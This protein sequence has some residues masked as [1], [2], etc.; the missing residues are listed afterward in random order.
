MFIVIFIIILAILIAS[1]EFGHFIVAKLSGIRVDEFG[2]GFPP[3]IVGKRWGETVYTLNWIPF[4]GFVR[5]FGEEGNEGPDSFAGKH[6]LIQAGV[7]VAG[8]VFNVLLAF[9]LLWVGL[10]VGLEAST[11]AFPG[12]HYEDIHVVVTEVVPDSPAALAKIPAGIQINK[13]TSGADVQ[14]IVDDDEVVNFMAAHVG[15]QVTIVAKE[16]TYVVT[17]SPTAGLRLD[18]VGTVSFSFFNAFVPAIKTTG[19]LLVGTAK[20]LGGLLWSLVHGTAELGNVSGPVGIAVIVKQAANIG[21]GALL[22][23]TVLLSLSLAVVNLIPFPALD[24]GR[25]LFIIIESIRRRPLPKQI[26]NYANTAGFALLLVLMVL[27][28]YHDIARLL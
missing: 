24:G 5:I 3:R 16:G 13:L 20:G 22:Q 6:R 26:A 23:L 19:F 4:G 9:V 1:H 25:L 27:I 7:V 28:T 10:T 11:S 17:P 12:G 21:F 15:K 8:I 2:L 14:N 18:N